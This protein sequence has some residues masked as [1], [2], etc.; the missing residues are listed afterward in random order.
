MICQNGK[1]FD[2]WSQ[3]LI[4]SLAFEISQYYKIGQKRSSRL[5]GLYKVV[6]HGPTRIAVVN[7]L[8][9]SLNSSAWALVCIS[10]GFKNEPC[11]FKQNL[12]FM[13]AKEGGILLF[14]LI[15]FLF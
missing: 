10:F 15:N 9:S 13:G 3:W 1:F 2:F 12:N 5:N 11:T 8:F 6:Y 14:I 4:D 7:W